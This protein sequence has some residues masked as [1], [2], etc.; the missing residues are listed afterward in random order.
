MV[1]IDSL[2]SWGPRAARSFEAHPTCVRPQ[3]VP[4][5]VN[6]RIAKANIHIV[7]DAVG[8]PVR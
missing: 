5:S 8:T 2:S 6:S 7:I 4:A 3:L 1:A